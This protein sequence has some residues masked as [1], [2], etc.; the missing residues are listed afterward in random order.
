MRLSNKLET[1]QSEFVGPGETAT[2]Q[3]PLIG[4]LPD[5]IALICLARVPRKYHIVLKC[6][7]KRWRDLVCSEEWHTYR[8]KNKLDETWIYALCRDGSDRVC[9]YVLDPARSSRRSW[10]LIPGLPPRSLNRK[11]MAFEVLGRKIYLL[12]GCGWLEDAT[13][14]VYSY[15]ASRNAWEVA[16]PLSTPRCYFA[17]EVLNKKI[18][19]IG[20]L[21]TQPSDHPTWDVYDPQCNSWTSHRDHNIIPDIE[22]SVVL[23]GKIYIRCGSSVVSSHVYA[24]VYNPSSGT[25]E[26][27]D[28][29]IVAGWR[30]PAV[31]VDGTLYVLDQSSG[32]RLMMWEKETRK[33]VALGRLSSL[34]TRPPCR[35][36]AIEKKIFVIGKGLSTVVFDLGMGMNTGGI[37]VSS[38]VP[39]L[40][41]DDV[42]ISCKSLS[43]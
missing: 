29:D 7:S 30:G 43:I 5:D 4:G 28:V 10:K 6:V 13:D 18:Y 24:V 40:I 26:H 27:A 42:V 33:W 16:A 36:I 22:D 37:V 31:V 38:S 9:C 25:W 2:T 14:E 19:A 8:Q 39:R 3:V 1:M 11:G 15:D 21:S 17:C 41:S 23:D 35:L 20:G 32:T 12:G 34:L